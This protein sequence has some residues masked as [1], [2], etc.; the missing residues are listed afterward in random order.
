VVALVVLSEALLEPLDPAWVEQ[1]QVQVLLG[2]QRI[3]SQGQVEGQ[4]V[5]PGRLAGNV[6][7][8]EAVLLHR[9]Q[10]HGSGLLNPLWGVAHRQVG[11][12]QRPV[13]GQQAHVSP[14]LA[15]VKANLQTIGHHYL[16]GL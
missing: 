14:L 12:K 4:P 10:P 15:E 11:L 16:L 1:V 7:P 8:F 13:G 2:Q 5:I 9:R 3:I 6:Q